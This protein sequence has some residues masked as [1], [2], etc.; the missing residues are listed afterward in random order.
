MKTIDDALNYADTYDS[1]HSKHMSIVMLAAEVR[2]LRDEVNGLTGSLERAEAAL[3]EAQ[4]QE[5]GAFW[6]IGPDGKDN[7][8]PYRG[9]PSDVAIDNARNMGCEPVLLYARPVPAA[10]AV[11]SLYVAFTDNDEHIRFWTR[12]KNAADLFR[13]N[14]H[15]WPVIE[16]FGSPL[17]TTGEEK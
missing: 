14:H 17:Q 7:G 13:I 6:W 1:P 8:G 15:D 2:R 10:P 3:K 9:K 4:E 16:F 5:P 11:P 12:S